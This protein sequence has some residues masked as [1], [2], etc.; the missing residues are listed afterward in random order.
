MNIPSC[1]R[2]FKV[3]KL[4]SR[5]NHPR[6]YFRAK[7][8]TFPIIKLLEKLKCPTII[9]QKSARGG[10]RGSENGCRIRLRS[11]CPALLYFMYYGNIISLLCPH[12]PY[13]GQHFLYA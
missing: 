3:T 8:F 9:S 1:N 13:A 7:A 6:S 10:R 4:S 5:I 12:I 2:L 11:P